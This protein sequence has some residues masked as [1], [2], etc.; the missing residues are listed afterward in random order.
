MGF[1]VNLYH[2]IDDAFLWIYQMFNT[3]LPGGI[4]QTITG[5]FFLLFVVFTWRFHCLFADAVL[6]PL[7]GDT[8]KTKSPEGVRECDRTGY[9]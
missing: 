8:R 7:W 5:Y 1:I 9:P 2:L 4:A 6:R 3:I